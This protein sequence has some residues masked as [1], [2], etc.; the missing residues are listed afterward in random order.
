M[1]HFIYIFIVFLLFG[2]KVSFAQ[3]NPN[4][5]LCA[6]GV[7]PNYTFINTNGPGT[8]Y[9]NPVGC[10]T[11]LF[12]PTNQFAFITLYIT[13]SG[14][15]NMLI[16]GSANTGYLDV[17]VY[18]IPSGQSPCAAVMSSANQ[19]ACNYASN[20]SGCV[21]IGTTFPC[22][23]SIGTVPVTAG[24]VLMVIVN[25][26][27]GSS[28]TFNL[29]LSSSPGS[30][31]SG[32]PSTVINDLAMTGMPI[33]TI[34]SAN[35]PVQLTAANNG[36]AWTGTGVSATGLF[37]PATAGVGSHVINYSIGSGP[38]TAAGTKTITVISSPAVTVNSASICSSQ[39]ATLVATANPTG[40]SY[41]WSPAGSLSS[42][43]TQV[44]LANPSI[45]TVY[46]V[47]YTATNGCTRTGT[48]QVSVNPTPALIVTNNSE[49]CQGN[50][51]NFTASTG[52]TSYTW[53]GPS[54]FYQS[55]T[56]N[57]VSLPNAMPN[58]SGTYTIVAASVAGCSITTTSMA[59]VIGTST[60]SVTPVINVCE[61][62]TVLLTSSTALTA[63]MYSWAGPGG[64]TSSVSNPTLT[65]VSLGQAGI[66]TITATYTGSGSLTCTQEN[67]TNVTII[68]A[69]TVAL[70]P[71]G[72]I[73]N[74]DV[75]NLTSPGGG[76]TYSWTGPNAFVSSLQNPVIT[77]ASIVN[78][79]TYA[80]S[81]AASGCIRTGSININVNNI[82]SYTTIPADV[83]LCE[84]FTSNLTAVGTGGSGMY[85]YMWNPPVNLGNYNSGNTVV[86]GNL[87]T[88]Y[89]VTLS[90]ANCP[91]TLP[92]NSVVTVSVN[93]LPVIT[94]G[95]KLS[96]CEPFSAALESSSNPPS[97]NCSWLFGSGLSYG[98]CNTATGFVFPT[99][100]TY[101]A[102][103]TVTDVNGC[104]NT[105]VENAY[106]TVFPKPDADFTYGP[107]NPTV[108][109][110]DVNFSDNSGIGGPMKKWHWKFGDYFVA[111]AND[112]SAFQNPSH[113]YDNAGTYT[114]SLAVIN[115]F[116]CADEVTKYI[117]VEEE[118]A[119]FIPN[120][121]SPTRSEGKN[122]VFIPQGIG[123]LEE[124]FTMAIYDRSGSL[125]Y[126]T[127]ELTKGWDGSIK[128]GKAVQG[129]YVYKISVQDFK[130]REK[131]FVGHVTVL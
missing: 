44:T 52:A 80:V 5:I 84:G 55:T 71:L 102:T 91:A 95:A 112:T 43:N 24:Q 69:S 111:E 122:D 20:S 119:L 50:A 64:F 14:N 62:A 42:A 17:I 3:C 61:G 10:S 98:Q 125:I 40:G 16:D 106:V 127:N 8:T 32:I 1:K 120:A 107:N 100:G 59:N 75:I 56:G 41:A 81:I 66:Y 124:T 65:G 103:L 93:P 87:T 108:L 60:V 121:F 48:S 86:T 6:S 123:F 12:A 88:T 63:N 115:T 109:I 105:H 47:T 92:V 126:K 2:S 19:I 58:M 78:Q 22:P 97:V 117:T 53:T 130:K 79:G 13:Q 96:G 70:S 131:Q 128:G 7:S 26:Y 29:S 57:T 77:N 94:V 74:N 27:S 104:Q 31:Q 36:G 25:N 68:P 101:N 116:D 85:N 54:S 18:N 35:T 28:N 129:V 113:V 4:V 110:N 45:S 82:L 114:V 23:S 46:T 73:C 37:N 11:G 67:T 72:T 39:S 30:A 38:C 89:T 15:L 90:D 51:L 9:A 33:N 99:S 49:V 21:Q 76:A 118:F 34:C 83:T